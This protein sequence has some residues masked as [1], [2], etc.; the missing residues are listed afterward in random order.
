MDTV[1]PERIRRKYMPEGNPGK[2]RDTED[3]PAGVIDSDHSFKPMRFSNSILEVF[4][5]NPLRS[6]LILS[7]NGLGDTDIE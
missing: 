6:R 3:D 5:L 1:P 4:P 7:V 2:D